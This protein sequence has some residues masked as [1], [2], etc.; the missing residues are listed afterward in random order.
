MEQRL[1]FGIGFVEH[2]R[3]VNN[4]MPAYVAARVGEALNG[5][6]KPL[7][8]ARL[9]VLGLTYKPGVNDVRESPALKVL[10][11]L[12]GAGA[13]CSYHD[14]YVPSVRIGGRRADDF[15]R[16]PADTPDEQVP[17][18]SSVHLDAEVLRG[19][20]CVVILTAHPGVDY[21][22]VVDSAPLVFDAAGVTR[23]QRLDHV[24][25]L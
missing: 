25:L 17:R 3:S 4:R 2:A 7:R 16:L 5:V 13:D 19:A 22:A 15:P 24:V 1:G 9:V 21:R 8:G 23:A 6:G 11:R 20:D 14:P 10:E 18:M 12:V